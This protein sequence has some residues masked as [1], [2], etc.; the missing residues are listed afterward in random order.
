VADSAQAEP[1]AEPEPASPDPAWLQELVRRPT[2][3]G[4]LDAQRAVLESV[5]A[6][7]RERNLPVVFTQDLT[8]AHPWALVD[9]AARADLPRLLFAVHVDTVPVG[10]LA[11][12]HFDPNGAE[13]EH[14]VLH[15]R[16]STDMKAG[17]VAATAAAITA[18]GEG[19]AVSL[20]LT[21]D[22]EI[23]SRGAERAAGTVADLEVGAVIIPEAT[24]NAIHRGHRG[25]LW[26]DVTTAGRAAHGSTPD[27][28]VNAVLKAVDLLERARRELPLGRDDFLR[29]ETWNVGRLQGGAATNIVP[30]QARMSIDHRVIGDGAELQQWWA[31]QP[32]VD[33]VQI[34]LAL[35]PVFTP[36]SDAWL[37]T[38]PWPASAEPVP[39][40][41]D[42]SALRPVV[43]AAPILI[44]GPGQPAGMH[45][46]NESVDLADLAEAVTRFTAV[47]RSW[48]SVD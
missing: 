21:S 33:E 39:Y 1:Q 9:V 44:W 29:H 13:I 28:G 5:L 27:R 42:G 40:F 3:S 16:G 46:A 25:A 31:A 15:G 36:G 2:V 19:H 17:V 6:L 30:D 18:I 45:V 10:N 4:D 20:L 11:D 35:D 43:G 24:A 14:G 47:A 41:T 22:E 8:G 12:W 48:R 7:V 34:A 38:L 26:L 32:E 23:G 37:Q